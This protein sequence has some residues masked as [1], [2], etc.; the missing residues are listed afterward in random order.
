MRV[1]RVDAEGIRPAGQPKGRAKW[2]WKATRNG[3]DVAEGSHPFSSRTRVEASIRATLLPPYELRF[4]LDG[5]L[6][7]ALYVKE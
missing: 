6:T 4:W 7:D 3:H 5:N 2:Y 1:M